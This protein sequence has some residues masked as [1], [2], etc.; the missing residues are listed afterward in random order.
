MN[1]NEKYQE[2][3]SRMVVPAWFD[4]VTD[5]DKRDAKTL[6]ALVARKQ[7]KLG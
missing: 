1:S 6:C 3:M 2:V 4:P 5:Q 7:K